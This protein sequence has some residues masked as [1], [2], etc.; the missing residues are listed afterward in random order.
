MCSHIVWQRE[1]L[2]FMLAVSVETIVFA[3]W[4]HVAFRVVYI[5]SSLISPWCLKNNIQNIE[6]FLIG[7]YSVIAALE[8]ILNIC[9]GVPP[10]QIFKIFSPEVITEYSPSKLSIFG[11]YCAVNW[12]NV[13]FIVQ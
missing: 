7:V 13:L 1:N 4:R 6:S 3:F 10:R 9:L 11:I 2:I 5:L 8:N 12:V